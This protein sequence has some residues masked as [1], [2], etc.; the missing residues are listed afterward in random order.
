MQL[1]REEF[2]A[3]YWSHYLI[4][5]NDL[6]TI[7][8]YVALRRVNLHTCSWRIS[9]LFLTAAAGVEEV[10]K[11]LYPDAS[12]TVKIKDL[13]K[14]LIEDELFFS[15][16]ETRVLRSLDIAPLAPFAVFGKSGKGIPTWWQEHNDLKHNRAASFEKA[17]LANLLDATAAY[18]QLCNFYMVKNSREWLKMASSYDQALCHP[19][20]VSSMFSL[21]GWKARYESEVPGW[22]FSGGYRD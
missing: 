8:E 2:L 3:Y 17:N 7:G 9:Q 6:G 10:L 16:Q 19:D 15:G 11:A 14:P 4:C 12:N 13:V 22:C 20:K 21:V 5:E 1:S 18:H